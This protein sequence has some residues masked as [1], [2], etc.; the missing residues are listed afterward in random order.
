MSWSRAVRYPPSCPPPEANCEVMSVPPR[1]KS[2]TPFTVPWSTGSSVP[3]RPA[4]APRLS[5]STRP[6]FSVVTWLIPTVARA[7]SGP[8]GADLQAFP[9]RSSASGLD[10]ERFSCAIALVS[11]FT[12]LTTPVVSW[13]MA[14]LCPFRLLAALEISP[15]KRRRRRQAPARAERCPWDRSRATRRNRRNW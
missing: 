6:L 9:H 3:P 7:G 5:S 12:W 11:E 13:L 8:A 4:T 2:V 1:K 14:A 10:L 15:A